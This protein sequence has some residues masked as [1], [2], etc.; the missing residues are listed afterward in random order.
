M[1]TDLAQAGFT[2]VDLPQGRLAY[3][4]AGPA[5][6]PYPPVVFVHGILVDARL[7]EPVAERLAARGVRSYAP[8]LP[9]GAHQLPMNAG[10]DLS[11]AGMAQLVRDFT[12]ALGLS[13]VTIVGN[14]TGGAICQ[15]I[16][17]GDTTRVGAAVLTNGD[18]FGKFPP[19]ALAPLFRALRH[20]GLVA[21][22]VPGMRSAAV[23]HGPLAYGL[24][25]SGAL[26]RQLTRDWVEALASKAVRHDLAT[27]AAGVRRG[28]LLDA[29]SRF[30][31]FPGPVGILWGDGDPFFPAELGRQL[32]EAFPRGSLTTVPGGRTF[33]SL[34]HPDE[35]A[36]EILRIQRV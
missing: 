21:C 32:S 24:L 25:S 28:V 17:G 20:P 2:V 5:D 19:R 11:P 30:S 14:D 27:F 18:A 9:L 23:R 33:L 8:T 1:I 13:G 22:L 31:Q 6:S 36:S 16:L 10:A 26:D 29:A 3:R 15:L 7:W 35:V 4:A 34:D 12:A